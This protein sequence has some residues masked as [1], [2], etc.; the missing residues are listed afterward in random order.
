MRDF[1]PALA[2]V[3]D[4]MI[5]RRDR[6]GHTHADALCAHQPTCFARQ[7]TRRRICGREPRSHADI[8]IGQADSHRAFCT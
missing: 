6:V 3:W 5:V 8:I 1:T 2:G 4:E 7:S